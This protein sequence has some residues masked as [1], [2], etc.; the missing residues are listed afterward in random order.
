MPTFDIES[1][2]WDDDKPTS[3][4]TSGKSHNEIPDM[5]PQPDLQ[6][7]EIGE[8]THETPGMPPPPPLSQEQMDQIHREI[9]DK[10]NKIPN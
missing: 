8:S 10:I 1:G 7:V 5:G 4:P 3:Q 6:I 2:E 9:W